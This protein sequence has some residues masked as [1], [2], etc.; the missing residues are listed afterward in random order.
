MLSVN[1]MSYPINKKLEIL[2]SGTIDY[3]P[4]GRHTLSFI[5]AFIDD[6]SIDIY[7]DND[8]LNKESY[9][10]LEVF[11]KNSKIN[12]HSN[13]N[14]TYDFLIYTYVLGLLPDDDWFKAAL[15][16]KAKLKICYPVCDGSVPP[17]EWINKI[18]RYFDICLSPSRYCSENFKRHGV[19]IDCI[20]LECSVLINKILDEYPQNQMNSTFRFGCISA[21][22]KRKNLPF[23]IE[24]FA[25]AF[26]NNENVEL[27]IHTNDRN[28]ITCSKEKLIKTFNQY[29]GNNNIIFSTG[30]LSHDDITKIWSSF[31]A[32]ICPQTATGYF[33]TPIEAMALGIPCIA[34]SIPTHKEISEYIPIKNNIFFVE[35]NIIKPFQHFIFDYRLMGVHLEA[36]KINYIENLKL[37]YKNRSNLLHSDLINARKKH[38]KKFTFQGIK[39][40]YISIIRPYKLTNN[41]ISFIKD[42]KF[43]ITKKLQQKYKNIYNFSFEKDT[44]TKPI[45]TTRHTNQ[46]VRLIEEISIQTQNIYIKKY[47][48][49]KVNATKN[50]YLNKIIE[51]SKKQNISLFL[52]LPYKLV[53]IYSQIKKLFKQK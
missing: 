14:K 49:E 11:F 10:I 44:K 5:G 6:V 22:E 36:S 29:N 51:I 50:K 38:A 37:I 8:Y 13:N 12:I 7:I 23:L 52:Y 48:K 27:F 17:I 28:D 47:F 34:S 30:F 26:S 24:A 35:H 46:K 31:H 21:N 53:K 32:Y 19:S 3:S 43:Y 2:I 1:D 18:N 20:N 40:K 15:Q 42:E 16:K 25:D 39:N 4:I 33:T 41:N 45:I 9:N